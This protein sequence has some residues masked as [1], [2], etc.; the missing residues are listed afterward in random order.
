MLAGDFTPQFPL[1]HATK[2]ATLAMDA[3]RAHGLD[4]SLT[5]TLLTHWRRAI[6]EDHGGD[7]VASAI[8]TSTEAVDG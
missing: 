1:Q 8:T 6:A 5:A 3:A 4:L 2:D 7:D